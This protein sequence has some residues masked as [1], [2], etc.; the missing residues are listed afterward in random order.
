MLGIPYSIA[1]IAPMALAKDL[2]QGLMR[3]Q[4]LHYVSYDSRLISHGGQ[5]LF[6]ALPTLNRDGH[7]FVE[8]AYRKGVRNFMVEKKLDLPGINYIWVENSLDALQSWA[9]AHRQRFDYPIWAITGSNGKTTVKEWLATLVEMELQ[10]VKSPMS[11]NSQLGVALSLL[12]LHPNVDLAIIEAGIS[13]PGEMEILQEIIQ[14]THGILTHMGS[15]HAENFQSLSHKLSEKL[16]LFEEVT[17]LLTSSFQPEILEQIAHLHPKTVGMEEEDHWQVKD[18]ERHERGSR[19]I[20]VEAGKEKALELPFRSKADVENTLLAIA[21][22]REMGVPLTQICQRLP[23]LHPIEMRTEIISD[24]PEITLINDSYNSDVDSVRNAFQQLADTEI[25]ADKW[26]IMSDVPHLGDQQE[27]IQAQLLKEATALV[28]EKRLVTIGPLFKKLGAY[29][30]YPSVEALLEELRVKDFQG[31]TILLKGARSFAL[32]KL[33]PRFNHKLN[34]TTFRIDL[35]ALVHNYRLLK[36]R[37]PEGTKTM[38]MV[39]AAS[40]GSGTWEI[41]QQ[42]EKEGATYLAVAYASEGIELRQAGIDLPIMVMNPDLSSL[43]SLLQ[44]DIEPEISNFQL[45]GAFLRAGRMSDRSGYRIHLK[46]DTG[47]GRLGFEKQDLEELVDILSQSPDTQVI[48]V[49]SHLAAADMEEEDDFSRGQMAE[50]QSMYDFLESRL[51]IQAFRHMLNT[52]GILRFPQAAMEMVRMGIG[53]YGIDPTDKQTD[54]VEVGSLLSNI[55]QIHDYPEGS[56]IGYGRAQYTSRPSRIAI[57]PIG[58]ADGIPRSVGEGKA[59]FLVRG[60]EAPTI[61]RIC[62][63]MLML[64]VT[65]IPGAHA[66]D[67]V[68][69]FGSQ[70]EHFLSIQTLAQAAGTIPYEILVRISPRVRRVYVKE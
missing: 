20:W 33:I 45:L 31:S 36:S 2:F 66:G 17:C 28:G 51:G 56:S 34:A 69:I 63:D 67:A 8:D 32:E 49:M 24:N 15:S 52:A 13:M 39:K 57:V 3:P 22:A 30:S 42:L 59:N 5:T 4:P 70:G 11:Y 61:G 1:E 68:L 46:L 23:L 18:W 43:E 47:M 7:D 44:F 35:A 9:M 29:R 54:L 21:V 38:C 60:Q 64:D 19:L 10:M 26:I 27:A 14:P 62:M 58:Y 50:F 65:D 6:V 55:T 25:H 53:L 12:Q 16:R 48:S 37:V 40:Y 41:A